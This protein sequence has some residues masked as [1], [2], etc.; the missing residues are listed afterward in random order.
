M[1][2]PLA[3]D[4]HA[5]IE[6]D[7]P[8]FDGEAFRLT[9]QEV[10]LT[11]RARHLGQTVIAGRAEQWDRDAVFPT[12]NYKDMHEH[13]LLGICVPK[14][15][16]GEGATFRAYCLSAAEIGRYCGTTA[17][18]WN[19]HVCSCLWTGALADDLDMSDEQRKPATRQGRVLHYERIVKDGAVYSQPF[20]EGGAAAAGFQPFSTQAR[21]VDG[22]YTVTG[23]KIFASLAGHADY[24]GVLCTLMHEDREPSRRDTLY[25]SIPAGRQGPFGDR[26]LGPARH[27]RHGLAHPPVRRRACRRP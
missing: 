10:D 19:M 25:L 3:K 23:R 26:R 20:S 9:D 14:E 27:A 2:Q 6:P 12:E 21:R 24:Y 7:A 16:G 11:A 17:L 1:T 13:G 15:Y 22:G 8:I 4:T 18:T 5:A